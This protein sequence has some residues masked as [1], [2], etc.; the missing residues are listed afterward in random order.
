MDKEKRKKFIVKICCAFAAFIL[1][2]YISNVQNP[3]VTKTIKRVPVEVESLDTLSQ[4]SLIA[5]MESGYTVDIT[6]KGKT[7]DVNLLE[8][9][10]IRLNA[11]VADYAVKEGDNKIPINIKQIPDNISVVNSS[12]LWVNVNLDSLVEKSFDIKTNV[13]GK[14][15][16]G[17]DINDII[18]SVKEAKVS[19]PSRKIKLVDSI[20]ADVNI[21]GF[22]GSKTLSVELRA[23]DA[24]GKSVD[25]V[26]INPNVIDM[27]IPINKVKTVPVKINTK[28]GIQ[29]GFTLKSTKTSTYELRITGED[30]ILNSINQIETEAVDLNG[31]NKNISKDINIIIPDGIKVLDNIKS[32]NVKIEIEKSISKKSFELPIEFISLGSEFEITSNLSEVTVTVSGTEEE[33]AKIDEK[34]IL[35]PIDLSGKTEGDYTLTLIINVKD[36]VT[37]DSQSTKEVK[38]TVKKK[39][40]EGTNDNTNQ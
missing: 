26:E 34:T 2:L 16:E 12:Q 32:I 17:Y 7:S 38:V 15:S 18:K 35:S 4:H 24:S 27:E 14:V 21:D 37:L 13:I 36:N 10:E 31:I 1:W 20:V 11:K 25:G 8:K 28:N 40:L 23:L 29:T 19:G 6:V 30:S 33:I 39:N 3:V 5:T 9:Q 22:A